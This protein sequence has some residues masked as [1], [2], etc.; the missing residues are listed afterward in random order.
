MGWVTPNFRIPKLGKSFKDGK[1]CG[2]S[3]GLAHLKK[4]ETSESINIK[5]PTAN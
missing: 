1:F 2:A 5:L 4:A 3:Q